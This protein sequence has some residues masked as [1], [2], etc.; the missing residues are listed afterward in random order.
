MIAS[1]TYVLHIVIV[2]VPHLQKSM[3]Y[4]HHKENYT[5]SL[6]EGITPWGLQIKKIP[7]FLPVSE[8][9]ESKWKAILYDVEN[10]I[11][12]LLMYESDQVIAKIEVQIQEE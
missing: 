12:K 11:V 4:K 8:D 10:N 6:K 5:K 9:F 3:H 1:V 2:V 7:A